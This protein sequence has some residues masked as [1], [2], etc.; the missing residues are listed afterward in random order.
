[1]SDNWEMSEGTPFPLGVVW[2][3]EERAY[4]FGSAAEIRT[5]LAQ[6]D[7]RPIQWPV[8]DGRYPRRARRQP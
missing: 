7:D 1:M 3:D 8:P 6:S 4:N 5:P 2:I